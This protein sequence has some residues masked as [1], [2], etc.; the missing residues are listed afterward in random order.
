MSWHRQLGTRG[1][2]ILIAHEGSRHSLY[3]SYFL[4]HS[5]FLFEFL[6]PHSFLTCFS[7]LSLD[8]RHLSDRDKWQQPIKLCDVINV[9]GATP[10]G[11]QLALKNSNPLEEENIEDSIR[12]MVSHG[13]AKRIERSRKQ[14]AKRFL[15]QV[16]DATNTKKFIANTRGTNSTASSTNNNSKFSWLGNFPSKRWWIPDIPCQ[17][18]GAITK[19]LDLDIN[20]F[21]HENVASEEIV[22]K[23]DLIESHASNNL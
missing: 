21:I 13:L 14:P 15:S 9:Y 17:I 12:P 22:A 8:S 19:L 6:Q 16:G 18:E 7:S 4:H 1:A 2:S 11:S 5:Q 3:I 23:F 20:L 10:Y